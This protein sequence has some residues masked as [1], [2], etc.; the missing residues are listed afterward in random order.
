VDPQRL[1]DPIGHLTHL[2]MSAVEAG[3]RTVLGLDGP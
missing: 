1:G 3:L 2:E